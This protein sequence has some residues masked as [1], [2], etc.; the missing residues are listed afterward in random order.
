MKAL[1]TGGAGFIGSNLVR[2]LCDQGYK[3]DVIDDFSSSGRKVIDKRANL[4]KGSIT[5]VKL[6]EK[7]LKNKDV[8]FHLA[9]TGIIKLSLENPPIYFE[10]NLMNGIKILNAMRKQGVKKIIYSSSSGIYGEPKKIP[11]KEDDIKEPV[12]PYGAAKYSFEHVLS[13]YYHSFGIVSISLRYYNVYGPGDE[14]R[15]LTRAVPK[16]IK[17][18]LKNKPLT[19][20]WGGQQKKDY[21]FIEDVVRANLLAAEKGK[22]CSFYN[23]GSGQ[24]HK[25][26]EIAKVLELVFGKKL[27]IKQMGARPGDPNVLIADIS[28][29]KRELGWEPKVDLKTGLR[30]T[31][32]Y[33]Q[34]TT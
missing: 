31:I 1:V 22:G 23:V 12:N 17:A 4:T 16:W 32:E 28:K 10:N 20:Y 34:Q 9:A 5:N 6:L 27:A 13:S 14:Q 25:M 2:Y 21:I 30:R 11:I 7:L 8:V 33:Y 24:G 3:V 26:S 29:I 19:M 15:P 18:A